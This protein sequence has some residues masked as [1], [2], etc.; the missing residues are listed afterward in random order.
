MF[1]GLVPSSPASVLRQLASPELM[2][3]SGG[4]SDREVPDAENARRRKSVTSWIGGVHQKINRKPSLAAPV[5]GGSA[6][7]NVRR[8]GFHL[9]SC[10]RYTS[11]ASF[12]GLAQTRVS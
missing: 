2:Q 9:T 12:R 5:R 6:A 4:V 11:A 8:V 7:H 1:T 3:D 10:A